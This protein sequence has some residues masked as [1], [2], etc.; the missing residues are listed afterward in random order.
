MN[1]SEKTPMVLI[2]MGTY[3][4]EAYIREQL[5]SIALQTHKKWNLLISDDGSDDTTIDIAREWAKEVGFE[6][7]IIRN[8][9]KQGFAQNFLSMACD[10]TLK[11]DF[12]A[13]AD[14]DD[15]WHPNK[16]QIGLD[17][18]LKIEKCD[19]PKLYC[20]RTTYVN[21]KLDIFSESPIFNRSPSFRN[22]LVQSLAGGNTMIFDNSVKNLLEKTGR[23]NIVS[24]DWWL[25]QL[26]S[27]VGGTVYYDKTP[28]VLYRQHKYALVGGN[29]SWR[30]QFRRNY[31]AL[32]GR[33]KKYLDINIKSL[34]MVQNS[35]TLKN[36]EI[37]L[38]FIKLRKA[39]FKSRL[40][41]L[42]KIRIYRQKIVGTLGIHAL[43][44]IN[45][46]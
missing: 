37:L 11:S 28:L 38:L 27:G 8:G 33:F 10:P 21:E 35:L 12:Y 34:E 5:D 25:Y 39:K 24:H 45:K 26:I 43:A 1:N 3:N 32:N 20:G 40:K 36:Q 31:Q 4:G 7:V 17:A 2:L 23:L 13:F 19:G 16:I 29:S 15:V 6:K 9:P 46:L 41:T 30:A 22:A 18:L 42:I 44:I 14:Q